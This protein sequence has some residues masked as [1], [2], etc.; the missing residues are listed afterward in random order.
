MDLNSG[1]TPTSESHI[2]QELRRSLIAVKKISNYLA[3]FINDEET[4]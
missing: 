1:P 3:Y 2:L 4:H